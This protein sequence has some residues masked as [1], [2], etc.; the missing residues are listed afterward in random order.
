MKKNA[1]PRTVE[2]FIRAFPKNV[3]E[4]LQEVRRTIRE[5]APEAKETISYRMLALKL[6][7]ACVV[8]F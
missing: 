2:E 8:Y 1:P 7:G 5:A 3:R 6:K 4:I